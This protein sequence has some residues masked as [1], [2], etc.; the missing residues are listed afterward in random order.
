MLHRSLRFILAFGAF[1]GVC[2]VFPTVELSAQKGGSVAPGLARFVGDWTLN[3]ELSGTTPSPDVAT[4][5]GGRRGRG[6]GI[7]GG[8]FGGRPGGG[9]GNGPE[10]QDP[11]EARKEAERRAALVQELLTPTTSWRIGRDAGE[12]IALT[13]ADGRTVRYNP[14][15]KTEKHQMTNGTI[16]TKSRWDHGELRQEISL[17]GGLNIIRTFSMDPS[18]DQLV[19]TTTFGG[20]RGGRERPFRVVYDRDEN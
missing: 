4:R 16:E 7:G 2:A 18:S 13:N 15:N 3:R 20:G 1:V 19:V 11:A 12:T 5:G 10:G 9:R 6:I 14:N 8:G 17:S